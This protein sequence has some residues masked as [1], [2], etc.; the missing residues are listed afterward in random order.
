M[1]VL[2]V[3]SLYPN[4]AQPGFGTFVENRLLALRARFP[5]EAQVVAPVPLYPSWLP[6]SARYKAY[7]RVPV[8][9]ARHGV[10][11][12][13]HAGPRCR[14]SESMVLRFR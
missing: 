1:R 2:C 9:E 3:S 12:L 11:V 5:V 8:E 13:H 4:A 7:S 10:R 6:G 14:G